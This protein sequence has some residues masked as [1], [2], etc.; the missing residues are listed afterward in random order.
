MS[1][2]PR[3]TLRRTERLARHAHAF[4]RFAHHPLCEAY[5]GEVFRIG[6]ARVCK[7]CALAVLGGVLGVLTAGLAALAPILVPAGAPTAL[8]VFALVLA[9]WLLWWASRRR[10]GK[11]ASRFAPAFLLSV[12]AVSGVLQGDV[13]GIVA[14]CGSVAIVG[15][16]LYE[17]RKRGPWREAC[18][19]CAEGL[20]S[21]EVCSGFRRQLRREK[22]VMRL[23]ARWIAEATQ[24][25]PRGEG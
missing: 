19:T 21:D 18:K 3:A 10:T 11:F 20:D 13:A 5:A 4:H 22:A 25:R 24:P 1:R 9:V 2:V 14:A 8:A 17:H 16:A 12:A 6:R 15:F 23:S 7:G